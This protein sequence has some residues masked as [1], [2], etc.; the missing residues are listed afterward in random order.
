MKINKNFKARPF[1]VKLLSWLDGLDFIVSL[2]LLFFH[3]SPA[4]MQTVEILHI[5]IFLMK[6]LLKQ[7]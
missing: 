6:V 4:T 7:R 2:A 1:S 3:P 5:V